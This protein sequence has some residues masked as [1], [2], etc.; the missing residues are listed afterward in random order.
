MARIGTPSSATA[1]SGDPAGAFS[2]MQT[3]CFPD[4]TS[5]S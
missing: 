4:A 5:G 1:C 3:R 2:R